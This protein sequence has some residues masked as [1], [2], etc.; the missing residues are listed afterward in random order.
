MPLIK[1]LL[2]TATNG[3]RHDSIPAAIEALEKHGPSH[4]VQ[5]TATEDDSYFRDDILAQFDAVAFVHS[6]GD[7]T[8]CIC[9]ARHLSH[10]IPQY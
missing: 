5:F 1:I 9:I 8:S 10:R 4:D 7:G 3:Y 6:L 2:F